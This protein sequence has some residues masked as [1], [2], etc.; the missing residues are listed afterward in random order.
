MNINPSRTRVDGQKMNHSEHM[1]V[2]VLLGARTR[3]ISPL[4]IAS[5]PKPFIFIHIPKCAGTSIEN[6][7]MNSCLGVPDWSKLSKEM[8]RRHC[9]PPTG[10][11]HNKI[12]WFQKSN[13]DLPAYFKFAF[14]RNPW[15]RAVSQVRYLQARTGKQVFNGKCISDN[16]KILC[17]TRQWLWGQDLGAQQSDYLTDKEGRLNVDFIGRFEHL[18]ADFSLICNRLGI[19]TPELPH[20]FKQED[21]GHYSTHYD[22][23]LVQQIGQKYCDDI[24]LFGYQFERQY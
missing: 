6:A 18:E 8:A 13:Y 10:R 14:V 4:M 21:L 24:R 16:L 11:Q 17:F 7:L 23:E 9:L 2:F 15:S 3:K 5:L 19:K 1:L 22:E 20:I 12:K